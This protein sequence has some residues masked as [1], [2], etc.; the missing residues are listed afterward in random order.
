MIERR[1]TPRVVGRPK[2]PDANV[3]VLN[4]K[5]SP[6]VFDETYHFASTRGLSIGQLVRIAVTTFIRRGAL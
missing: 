6:T 3:C 5:V 4:T 1:A 2:K